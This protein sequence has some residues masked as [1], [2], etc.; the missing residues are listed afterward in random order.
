MSN[1]T[2]PR[3]AHLAFLVQVRSAELELARGS[4]PP[5]FR[6]GRKCRVLE[7]GA[8]TGAQAK[9]LAELGYQVTALDIE[10]SSYRDVREFEVMEY[11]GCKIPLPDQS[12]D[13]IF[14]SHVLEH[15]T[16]LDA[17]LQETRR[18]LADD[19][20]CVHIVPTPI[21]RAWTLLAHYVWLSRRVARK[22]MG[23]LGTNDDAE[24]E[25]RTPSTARAWFWTLFPARHGERGNAVTEIYWY[26][27]RF[28]RGAFERGRFELVAT[29][30]NGF[31]YT[32]ANSLGPAIG[33]DKR[34]FLARVL[35]SASRVYV[36][37]KVDRNE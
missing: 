26:S 34:C 20:V 18:V 25:P 9:S 10:S 36:L 31:F 3:E 28:W 35:G 14:S 37:R 22:A 16:R 32:M 13:V 29:A 2:R 11:D 1:R 19:G 12:Q 8:G 21:C 33:L 7:I 30:S 15:V 5:S 4:F 23:I 27:R 6:S 24:D 17:V